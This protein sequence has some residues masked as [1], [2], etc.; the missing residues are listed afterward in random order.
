MM[1]CD[2]PDVNPVTALVTFHLWNRPKSRDERWLA[3]FTRVFILNN[4]ISIGASASIRSELSLGTAL[5]FL[6]G[7]VLELLINL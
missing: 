4:E 7:G 6:R 3:Y 1:F 2:T 5:R